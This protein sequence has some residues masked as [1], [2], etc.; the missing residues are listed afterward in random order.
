MEKERTNFFFPFLLP[1]PFGTGP[2]TILVR[3]PLEK[4]LLLREKRFPFGARGK[5]MKMRKTAPTS[6]KSG[7]LLL[8]FSAP[9]SLPLS[10]SEIPP[11]GE[12]TSAVLILKLSQ[13][14]EEIGTFAAA[15]KRQAFHRAI[16]FEKHPA[17]L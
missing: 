4:L 15:E 2:F 9:L 1:L 13:G 12:C 17:F 3:A 6:A 8:G 5:K 7:F 11:A 16:C 14:E 10:L